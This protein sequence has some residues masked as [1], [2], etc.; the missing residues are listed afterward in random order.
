MKGGFFPLG[1]YANTHRY[2][3]YP[4]ARA[5]LISIQ[6]NRDSMH[7][8]R[9][10][11]D[12]LVFPAVWVASVQCKVSLLLPDLTSLT[13]HVFMEKFSFNVAIKWSKFEQERHWNFSNWCLIWKLQRKKFL[14]PWTLKCR[15]LFHGI[16]VICNMFFEINIFVLTLK[17]FVPIWLLLV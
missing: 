12:W 16:I 9:F 11:I 14:M 2:K 1:N 4:S 6:I 13:Y 8:L 7:C 3:S 10:K 17:C 15:Q 5:N